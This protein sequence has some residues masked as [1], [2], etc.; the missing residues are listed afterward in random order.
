MATDPAPL[1]GSVPSHGFGPFDRTPPDRSDIPFDADALRTFVAVC[2]RGSFRAAAQAVHRSPAAI[3]GRIA[4]LE[5]RLGRR[6][7]EREGRRVR[8]NSD[9][10]ALLAYARRMLALNEEIR[11]RFAASGTRGHVRFGAPDDYGTRWLPKILKVFARTHPAVRVDVTL[12]TST[13][14]RDGIEGGTVDVG[15]VTLGEDEGRGDVVHRE[16]LVW[17]GAASGSAAFSSE[18]PLAVASETC[19]WRRA[20]V[21]ACARAGRPFRIALTSEHSAGQIAALRADLAVAPLPESA[22]EHGLER[23]L[24]DV[25]PP[26]PDYSVR[27]LVRADADAAVRALAEGI[28]ASVRSMGVQ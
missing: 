3:S 7:F 16:P 9:G 22:I 28:A 27:L 1:D 26:L 10:E 25:L 19:A 17:A 8:L 11:A 15:L 20:A 12:A 2:E 4:K 23:V 14:V 5:E 13:A 21:D 6:V 18:L 24:P